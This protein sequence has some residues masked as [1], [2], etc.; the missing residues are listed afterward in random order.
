[1]VTGKWQSCLCLLV[2]NVRIPLCT[3]SSSIHRLLSVP[4]MS[5]FICSNVLIVKFWL[6]MRLKA[7]QSPHHL[8]LLPLVYLYN[9]IFFTFV[10]V[11]SITTFR[12]T[13]FVPFYT[14][15]FLSIRQY[16]FGL[17]S[18]NSVKRWP[19]CSS[20]KIDQITSWSWG[21]VAMVG[22]SC[23]PGVHNNLQVVYRS[24]SF[25]ELGEIKQLVHFTHFWTML[26]L[27]VVHQ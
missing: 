1:M 13:P 21:T 10:F 20:F 12:R 14:T 6:L 9:S 17:R 19:L 18:T 4:V 23:Q 22:T 27:L 7:H 15:F 16:I 25:I 26:S 2:Y 8:D 11:P 24:N 3:L 5:I